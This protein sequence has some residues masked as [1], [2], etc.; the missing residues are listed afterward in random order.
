MEQQENHDVPWVVAVEGMH[1]ARKVQAFRHIVESELYHLLNVAGKTAITVH[2]GKLIYAYPSEDPHPQREESSPPPSP[3]PTP[4]AASRQ[5]ISC[6]C[7]TT[8]RS[9]QPTVQ[10]PASTF[11]F[12]ASDR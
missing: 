6:T 10:T 5:E 2:I 12:R 1:G 8:E 9:W 3:E 11:G 4:P 7:A